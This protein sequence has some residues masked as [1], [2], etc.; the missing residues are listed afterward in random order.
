VEPELQS[1][2]TLGAVGSVSSE[3]SLACGGHASELYRYIS[4][5]SEIDFEKFEFIAYDEFYYNNSMM[6]AGVAHTY[7]TAQ[8]A[9]EDVA[10]NLDSWK[11]GRYAPR[12]PWDGPAS[13]SLPAT[14][15]DTRY[16]RGKYE[17]PGGRQSCPAPRFLS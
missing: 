7:L 6:G 13:G 14:N 5:E 17:S 1:G 9:K 16:S 2:A 12:I 4:M 15:T 3:R 10:L 8:W 11:Y